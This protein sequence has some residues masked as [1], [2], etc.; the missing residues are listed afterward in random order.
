MK[1]QQRIGYAKT[2]SVQNLR[3]PWSGRRISVRQNAG[4]IGLLASILVWISSYT[5]YL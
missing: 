4:V 1:R 5:A 3:K 2:G